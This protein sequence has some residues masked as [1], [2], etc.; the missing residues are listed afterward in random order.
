MNTPST[1]V[2]THEI[3]ISRGMSNPDATVRVTEN[4]ANKALQAWDEKKAVPVPMKE[5]EDRS[6][7]F[8]AS[9]RIVGIRKRPKVRPTTPS[10]PE[11]EISTEQR[12]ERSEKLRELGK[13]FAK[14]N[15]Q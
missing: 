14:D 13:K 9:Y 10:L 8:I 5:H 1:I 3:Y 6:P 15:H 11:V 4:E 2:F 7:E 12:R